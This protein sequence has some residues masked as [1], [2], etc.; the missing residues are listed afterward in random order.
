M[1]SLRDLWRDGETTLGLWAG[2]PDSMVAESLA[3]A[4]VAYV[5]CDNQHGLIDYQASVA[6]IQGRGTSPASSA[7]C[8]TPVPRA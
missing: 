4:G 6:M 8:S 2:I 7:S 1:K 3:R 5:C